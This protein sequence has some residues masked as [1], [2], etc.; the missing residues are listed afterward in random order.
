[1]DKKAKKRIDRQCC[2]YGESNYHLLDVHRIKFG[3]EYSESNTITTCSN[4]H[5][6]IH[7]GEIVVL[8]KRFCTNGKYLVHFTENNEEKFKEI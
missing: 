5:R 2:L 8:G 7:A 6:R 4:C 3:Q 1:M